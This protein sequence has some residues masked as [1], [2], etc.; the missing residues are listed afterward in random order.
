MSFKACCGSGV[1]PL[2]ITSKVLFISSPGCDAHFSFRQNVT[3]RVSFP[4]RA[5]HKS[6]YVYAEQTM[7]RYIDDLFTPKRWFEANVDRILS[8]YAKDHRL[9]KE[10]V[11]LS[12]SK[13]LTF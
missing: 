6:A 7:Y 10:D 1:D 8:L 12:K 2:E 4:I 11:Y 5:G 9:Q 13:L 3:R